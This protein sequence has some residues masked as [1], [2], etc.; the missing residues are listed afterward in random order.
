MSITSIRGDESITEEDLRAHIAAL[1]R[2]EN[3]GI[4]LGAGASVVLGGKTVEQIWEE[5]L[6]D[7]EELVSEL[8]QLG[9]INTENI[10]LNGSSDESS[11]SKVPNIELLLDSLEIA[12]IDWERCDPESTE[13]T[14]IKE[15]IAILNCYMIRAAILSSDKWQN[16][17]KR[18]DLLDSHIKLLQRIIGARQP[19][20]PSPWIFTT[21]YDLAVEWASESV[22]I[23]VHTGFLGIHNRTFSPHSFDLGFQNTQARGEARF[24]SNDVY[25]VKLHGSLT[26]R[27]VN[28]LDYRELAA[29]EAWSELKE[30]IDS[31]IKPNDSIMVF[32]RAAKYIQSVGFLGGELFRRFSD[33]LAKPQGCLLIFGYSFSD[34]HL[35]RLIRSALLNPTLQIVAFLP[36]LANNSDDEISLQ[37]DAVKELIKLASPRLT[38]VG[39]GKYIYFD[40][41]V[42]LLP[43]PV[44]FNETEREL[45]DRIKNA[46]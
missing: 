31:D 4:F 45:L 19:G 36:E 12:K 1:L 17:H 22:G 2:L 5:V 15:Y 13:L 24:G 44:L 18:F 26:W 11:K 40:K 46:K 6:E 39:G 9:F 8:E 14:D 28:E 42:K 23:H 43:T 16:P 37:N 29:I 41:A 20:Q 33:F 3:V 35:N 10:N 38:L 32:L 25:L 7:C 34:K 21:N 30:I 27:R